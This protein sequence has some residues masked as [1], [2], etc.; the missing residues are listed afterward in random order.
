[1][2]YYYYDANITISIDILLLNERFFT[3]NPMKAL[4]LTEISKKFTTGCFTCPCESSIR[5]VVVT[6]A[7]TSKPIE[8]RS[9]VKGMQ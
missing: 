5:F 7:I 3:I 9:R 4:I 1:M 6:F 2:I 8:S